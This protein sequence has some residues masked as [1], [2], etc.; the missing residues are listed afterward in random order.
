MSFN[1]N[2]RHLLFQFRRIV[3]NCNLI[4]RRMYLKE[5]FHRFYQFYCN[6]QEKKHITYA[7]QLYKHDIFLVIFYYIKLGTP[8]N[9]KLQ[10]NLHL[11]IIKWNDRDNLLMQIPQSSWICTWRDVFSHTQQRATCHYET[12]RIECS[13]DA[14]TG[15]TFRGDEVGSTLQQSW[16]ILTELQTRCVDG[17]EGKGRKA[18]TV[19]GVLHF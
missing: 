4:F 1:N 7:V 11:S 17:R 19:A 10:Y 16:W 13:N 3:S 15:I 8:I 6:T 14:H 12:S 9:T 2:F 5:T 18:F